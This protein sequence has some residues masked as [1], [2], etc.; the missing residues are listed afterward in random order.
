VGLPMWQPTGH[1]ERDEDQR[2]RGY[3]GK[4]DTEGQRRDCGWVVCI[5]AED[6]VY[7]EE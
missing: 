4:G 2:H 6:S 7:G 3:S 1:V 5:N